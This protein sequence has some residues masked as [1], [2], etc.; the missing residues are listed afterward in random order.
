V[1]AAKR[2]TLLSIQPSSG[3]SPGTMSPAW[4]EKMAVAPSSV[5]AT[6]K[7]FPAGGRPSRVTEIRRRFPVRRS[8]R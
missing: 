2:S 3:V 8:H 1:V 4:E 5:I 7:L 6:P